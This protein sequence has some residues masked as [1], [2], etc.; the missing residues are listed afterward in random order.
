MSQLELW[1]KNW[2]PFK[3]FGQWPRAWDRFFD[4]IGSSQ[5]RQRA[6]SPMVSPTVDVRETKTHYQ[7]KFDLPG[8][9]K[10]QIKIDLND[11]TLT[12][13]G[14][15][16][17]EKIERSEDK[18]SHLSEVYYGSFYRSFTFPEAVNA[19]KSEARYENGVLSLNI[20]K[21]ETPKKRQVTI[22]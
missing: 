19:E 10:D 3:E 1:K 11:N 9:T 4:E 17:E 21:L 20:P 14:E 7:M 18:R 12:V 5:L 6:D 13:S 15:R 22:M 8:M 2:E 16:N